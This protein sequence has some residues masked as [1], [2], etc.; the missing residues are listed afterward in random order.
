MKLDR[1]P[2]YYKSLELYYLTIQTKGVTKAVT[3]EE[4]TPAAWGKEDTGRKTVQIRQDLTVVE[5]GLLASLS[6]GA[7]RTAIMLMDSLKMNNALWY[8]EPKHSR[9]YQVL[10]ELREKGVLIKTED[11]HIHYVN[12]LMIRRGSAGSV[13][14]QTTK[15]LADVSRVDQSL[16]HDLNYSSVRFN[17]FDKL[18]ASDEVKRLEDE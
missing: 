14:A 5:Q 11:T 3:M 6:T 1:S 4:I 7:L 9:D 12:P 16:I 18:A 10:R 17:Q 2:T 13:L 8:W 15:L